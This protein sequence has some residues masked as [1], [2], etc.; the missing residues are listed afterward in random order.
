MLEH[1]YLLCLATF[2]ISPEMNPAWRNSI[3]AAQE[4]WEQRGWNLIE[5]PTGGKITFSA[6]SADAL[7]VENWTGYFNYQ[8]FTIY[9]NDERKLTRSNRV[10][11]AT[12][13]FGHALGFKH[14]ADIDSIMYPYL[15]LPTQN[16]E[17]PA[18]PEYS[19]PEA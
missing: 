8:T 16:Y 1:Y 19:C 6:S 18:A 17:I 10:V 4:I 3:Y 2:S 5:I 11:T 9:L 12:H 15:L 13:E 14:A 7:P